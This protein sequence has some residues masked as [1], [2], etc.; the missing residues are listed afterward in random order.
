M[1]VGAQSE[2]ESPVVE[3]GKVT[4]RNVRPD[5]GG[6]SWLEAVVELTVGGTPGAGVYSRNVDRVRVTLNIGIRTRDN[7]FDF[8][9]ATAEAVSLRSGRAS[10]RFYLPPE[11]VRNEQ[12]NSDPYAY[13]VD[14]AVKGRPLPVGPGNGSSVLRAADVVSSFKD[15][16][17][18]AAPAN[19]GVMV[20]QYDSPFAF[21]YGNDTP[22]FVRRPR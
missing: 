6:D 20:P 2:A 21:S 22:S 14:L 10:I 5:N 7:D 9:R 18:R 8:Y 4:F 15:R 11:I 13:F 12:I 17:V 19:D 16:V 3:V 1:P